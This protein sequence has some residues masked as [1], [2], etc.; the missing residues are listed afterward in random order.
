MRVLRDFIV[1][2]VKEKYQDKIKT[3]SGIELYKDPT[4]RPEHHVTTDG[5][6]VAI[7][8]RL[9]TQYFGNEGIVPEVRVG[10]QVY[11]DYLTVSPSNEIE[12]DGETMYRVEYPMIFAVKRDGAFIM[13][14]SH[15]FVEPYKEVKDEKIG[16]IYLPESVRVKT[17]NNEGTILEIGNALTQNPKLDLHK[18]D[19]VLFR[20]K[21]A[22]SY[23]IDNK[24]VYVMK[25][26]QIM[27]KINL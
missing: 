19:R 4:F 9:S 21:A 17:C 6:C 13:I 25:Q 2:R 18:G 20:E 22:H 3:E 7:P 12:F 8:E 11:F 16:L 23:N 26:D 24:D 5:E 1:V 14:G 27:A 10:D 15:V